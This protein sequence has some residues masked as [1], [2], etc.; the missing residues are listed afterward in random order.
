MPQD[1]QD[2]QQSKVDRRNHK[3]VH[4]A[5]TGHMIAQERLPSLTRPG[6]TVAMYLATVDCATSIPSFNSSP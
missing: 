2:E 5:D 3:E 1:D 6:P 4:G